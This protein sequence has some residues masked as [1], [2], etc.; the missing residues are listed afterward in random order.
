MNFILLI[1]HSFL[2][3]LSVC[4]AISYLRHTNK[5]VPIIW[6]IIAFCWLILVTS[7]V[8]NITT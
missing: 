6:I 7:D 2:V 1:L 4:N 5:A 3:I 8:C